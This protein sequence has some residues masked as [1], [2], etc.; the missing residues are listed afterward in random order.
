[1]QKFRGYFNGKIKIALSEELKDKFILFD[2]NQFI[3]V[4]QIIVENSIDALK[5][6]GVIKFYIENIN[7]KFLTLVIEDNGVG[8]ELENQG[9]IFEPYYTT[10]REGTGLG[11]AFAKKIVEDNLGIIIISSTHGKGTIVKIKLRINN[12]L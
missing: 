4:I 10:K 5:G 12:E 3:E 11:L 8:I 2:K 7:D 9:K 1:M 6:K